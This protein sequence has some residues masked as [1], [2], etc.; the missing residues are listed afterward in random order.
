MGTGD[1]NLVPD[2]FLGEPETL[3]SACLGRGLSFRGDLDRRLVFCRMYIRLLRLLGGVLVN[4]RKRATFPAVLPSVHLQ[5]AS[6]GCFKGVTSSR[7]T[8]GLLWE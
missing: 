6:K 3:L 5:L 1:L 2:I 7:D 4:L 8:R